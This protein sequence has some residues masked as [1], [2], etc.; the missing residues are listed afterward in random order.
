MNTIFKKSLIASAMLAATSLMV[1]S[2]QAAT[3]AE[4]K[5]TGKI[6]PPSC[7]LTLGGDGTVDFGSTA[8]NTLNFDGTK[9]A[10][11]T[12]ALNIACEGATR[13][14]LAVVDNRASSKVLKASLNSAAWASAAAAVNDN[15]IYGL[16]MATGVDE[17]PVQ[18]GGVMIGFKAGVATVDNTT[19]SNVI[20]STDKM[21]WAS[22]STLRQYLS[23]I[24]TY[25]FVKG[26]YGSSNITPVPLETVSGS[27]SVVPTITRSALLPTEDIIEF[28]G[29]A[30]I[31]LVYL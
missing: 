13:V 29:S 22:D 15:F 25:S 24:Y 31:S 4:L 11:M 6:T 9:V 18:I 12:V 23:P 16:G 27:L 7:A 19:N 3:S 1:A 5:I 28:D 20:Y 17:K 30:T 8:F 14:G 26:A 10:E 2:A 21:N